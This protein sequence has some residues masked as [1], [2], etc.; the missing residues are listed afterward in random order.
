MTYIFT[1][2]FG[3]MRPVGNTVLFVHFLKTDKEYKGRGPV[4][5]QSSYQGKLSPPFPVS[6]DMKGRKSKR[7]VV[8]THT[9]QDALLKK[10]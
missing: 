8:A 5:L 9:E 4:F 3:V 10:G 1:Q 7:S 2:T 6:W